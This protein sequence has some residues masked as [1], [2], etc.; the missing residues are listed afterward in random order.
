[1]RSIVTFR[2]NAN[3][4]ERVQ[5]HRW[6][7]PT[8]RHRKTTTSIIM[9]LCR[10]PVDIARVKKKKNKKTRKKERKK[11]REEHGEQHLCRNV[12]VLQD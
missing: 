12:T 10:K 2:E 1:M 5:D 3:E 9:G 8:R 4:R 7:D 11:E 6:P